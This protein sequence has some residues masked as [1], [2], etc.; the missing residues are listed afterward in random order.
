[1]KCISTLNP[2]TQLCAIIGHPVAHSM[3]PAI[4]NAAFAALHLNFVYVAFPTQDVAGAIA[5]MR[6]LGNFRG[7]SVTIPHKVAVFPHLDDIAPVD[8]D[9][10]AIN[11]VVNDNGVLRGLGTDGPGARLALRDADVP[12]ENANILL[13]GSGGAA[14]AI[15]FDLARHAHPGRL[16]IA[17]IDAAERN[18][19]AHD[20]QSKTGAAVHATAMDADALQP[21]VAEAQLLINASPVGMHPHVADSPIPD[22]WLHGGLSVMD[23]VYNPLDTALLQAARA[24]GLQAISGLEMFIN[25]AALQ[26][27]AWT[28]QPAPRDL[29]RDVARHQLGSAT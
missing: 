5:G 18:A 29:M 23:I 6:A 19:L 3:S 1:M 25:Q 15:A 12:L 22:A 17:G 26:F 2:Q 11:T 16:T 27:E 24:K 10:G 4:H 7:L 20:L 8:R 21:Q 28:Q 9:I 13:I 14:R